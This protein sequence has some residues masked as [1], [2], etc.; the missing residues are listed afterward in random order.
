MAL[1]TFSVAN[2]ATSMSVTGGTATAHST[3]GQSVTNGIHCIDTTVSD[4]RVQPHV[5]FKHRKPQRRADGSYT[6]GVRSIIATFPTLKADGS[7]AFNVERYSAEYDPEV[8]V[9]SQTNHRLRL[10][11]MLTQSAFDGFHQTGSVA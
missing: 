8:S 3:D 9:A 6:K 11:Q 7:V 10:A 1:T 2:G 4:F 5:T